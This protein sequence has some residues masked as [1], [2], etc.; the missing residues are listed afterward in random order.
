M[1][2]S[3]AGLLLRHGSPGSV[4]LYLESNVDGR[5]LLQQLQKRRGVTATPRLAR[6]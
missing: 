1:L 2:E 3:L 4:G 6:A 5:L